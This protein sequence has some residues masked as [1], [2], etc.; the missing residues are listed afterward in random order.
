M[1]AGGSQEEVTA[2]KREEVVQKVSE[3][4]QIH[5][6]QPGLL[7]GILRRAIAVLKEFLDLLMQSVKEEPEVRE[8]GKS[9]SR[10]GS[11]LHEKQKS[12]HPDSR[13]AEF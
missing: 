7:A 11:E 12:E 8:T 9:P 10:T 4:V 2:F 6:P 1:I 5:G 13:D 3:S